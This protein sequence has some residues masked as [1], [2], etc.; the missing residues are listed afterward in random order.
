MTVKTPR[1]GSKRQ[2]LAELLQSGEGLTRKQIQ[3]R[4]DW[5]SKDVSDALRLLKD[6]NG[7]VIEKTADDRYRAR[8]KAGAKPAKKSKAKAAA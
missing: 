5:Q 4:F 6:R 1:E 2:K 7:F 8:L 3:S